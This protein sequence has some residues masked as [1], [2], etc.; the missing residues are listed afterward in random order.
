[1][2]VHVAL[3]VHPAPEN[4]LVVGGGD[5]GTIREVV[6]HREVRSAH[7]C[8]IDKDVVRLCRKHFPAISS[9]LTDERVDI[10]Y[11][12]GA[13][14]IEKRKNKY[15]VIIVD[16]SDPVGPAEVLFKE[17]FYRDMFEALSDDGIVVTQSESFQYH[18][19][20]IKEIASFSRKIFP[21]YHYYYTLVPTYP[22][23]VIGFSFCSRKYHPLK[24]FKE[25]RA[26]ELPGLRYYTPEIHRAAFALPCSFRDF[27]K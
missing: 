10:F 6:K 2:I 20:T 21:Y 3:N 27:L 13:A 15:Q 14:F 17:K 19:K 18:R 24:D 12:D 4:V 7:L 22:S 16:S 8:E 9:G 23:G 25:E 26:V 1:M 11:E 5:G